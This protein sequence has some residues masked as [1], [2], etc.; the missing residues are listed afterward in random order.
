MLEAGVGYGTADLA[1][2]MMRPIPLNETL[3]AQAK[4]THVS[5][6]LG[7]GRRHDS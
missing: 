2:K 7:G 4:V 3:I 5:R 6:S 1:I